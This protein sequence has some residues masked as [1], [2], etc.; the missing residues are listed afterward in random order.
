[1]IHK[2][3]NRNKRQSPFVFLLNL[4][5][6]GGIRAIFRLFQRWFLGT[7]FLKVEKY[8]PNNGLIIDLGCGIGLFSNLLIYKEPKR[9][10]Y[11][12]DNDINK[13]G[14]AKKTIN[15]NS[16]IQFHCFELT[17]YELPRCQSI[18]LYDVLHHLKP[19][20]QVEIL[21]KSYAAL[22]HKGRLV[23]KENDTV[24]YWKLLIN[25]LIEFVAL[26]F[27]LTNS[28]PICFR[29]RQEWI[30]IVTDIGFELKI[31]KH[32]DYWHPWSHSILVFT[33]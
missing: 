17:D 21:R 19:K 26:G 7:P 23:I 30:K 24:P 27:N 18:I 15:S 6:N 1:M 28:D 20:A 22:N 2:I 33:K 13:I 29:S 16:N 31:E 9:E 14:I 5:R 11:G 3:I 8:V 32:L 4:Y 12:I 25:Y 10:V